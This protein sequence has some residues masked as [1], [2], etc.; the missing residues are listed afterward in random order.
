MPSKWVSPLRPLLRGEFLKLS[1][2]FG[3]ITVD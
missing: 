1:H 3:D 2:G